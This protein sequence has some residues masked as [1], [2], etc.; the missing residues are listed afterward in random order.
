[1]TSINSVPL[2][3]LNSD[4]DMP[5]LG[6]GVFRMSTEQAHEAVLAALQCGYSSIDTAA[7]YDNEVG[8][9]R[10]VR[11]SGLPRESVFVTTK[12]WP[13]DFGRDAA[14]RAF[15]ASLERLGLD[16]VDLYLLH[17]PAPA[18]DLYVETWRVLE[19]LH[20]EGRAR[21]IGV[22]N[23]QI[24]HLKRLLAEADVPPA[25][26]QIELHPY[27]QQAELREF[28]ASLGIAT[29]AWSPLGRGAVEDATI[30]AVAT[31]HGRSPAQVILR[32]HMQIGTI[33]IPKSATPARI[34]DNIAIFD[35]ALDDED[36]AAI[37]DLD[38]GSRRGPDPE[39]FNG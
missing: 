19:E 25:V 33:A 38:T 36:M 18:R 34:C 22:S 23:F 35:F 7:R 32:W 9:G 27:F 31:R 15:D 5:R 28:H 4:R 30:K 3:R 39:A 14:R 20:R 6:I 21:S 37:A 12:L 24:P 2:V 8:V 1:M 16:H 29:E 11:E 13:T 17:W 26:N 10:A